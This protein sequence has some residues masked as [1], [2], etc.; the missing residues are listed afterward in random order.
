MSS[1]LKQF[2]FNLLLSTER[3]IVGKGLENLSF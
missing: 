2:N 3:N 1:K